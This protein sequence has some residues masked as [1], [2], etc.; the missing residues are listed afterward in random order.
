MDYKVTACVDMAY[1]VMAYM[2]AVMTSLSVA[3]MVIVYIILACYCLY[4]NGVYR[5]GL[6][7]YGVHQVS[8]VHVNLHSF[9]PRV[10]RIVHNANAS[11]L[12]TH[13]RRNTISQTLFWGNQRIFL[14]SLLVSRRVMN[15]SC[16][17]CRQMCPGSSGSLCQNLH[18]AR[19]QRPPIFQTSLICPRPSHSRSRKC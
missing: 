4:G 1:I 18:Q 10:K 12:W 8:G 3:R 2:Y 6:H 15:S 17:L 13:T 11:R 19:A 16:S 7:S 14:S 5:H 9:D